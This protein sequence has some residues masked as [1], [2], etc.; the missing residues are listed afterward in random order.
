M[1]YRF[2]YSGRIVLQDAMSKPPTSVRSIRLP[3]ETW[4]WLAFEAEKRRTTV[5]GLVAEGVALVRSV[6]DTSSLMKA[7]AVVREMAA[8]LPV[9]PAKARK[10]VSR[11]KGEWKAP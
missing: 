9:R 11:L 10:H 3:D 7:A 4:A 1:C 5:N 2:G 8:S 6:P